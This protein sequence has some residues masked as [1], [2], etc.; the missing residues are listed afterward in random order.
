MLASLT[1]APLGTDSQLL[2]LFACT[3]LKVV[4]IFLLAYYSLHRS[5]ANYETSFSSYNRHYWSAKSST[6][7]KD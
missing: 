3:V 1:S 2:D 4:L 7:R 5:I 6:L